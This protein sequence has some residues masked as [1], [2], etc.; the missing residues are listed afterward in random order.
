MERSVPWIK[1]FPTGFYLGMDEEESYAAGAFAIWLAW[2]YDA[3][4][5]GDI[6]DLLMREPTMWYDSLGTFG[7]VTGD[8]FPSMYAQFA[9]DFWSQAYSPV[10]RLNLDG[11]LQSSTQQPVTRILLDAD[12]ALVDQ[13]RPARSSIRQGV[14][15]EDAFLGAALDRDLVAR[16]TV[17]ADKGDVHVLK[18]PVCNTIPPVAF[19]QAAWLKADTPNRLLGKVGESL[20]YQVILVNWSASQARMVVEIVAPTI[21]SLF[22]VQGSNAGGYQLFIDGRGFGATTG[23]VAIGGFALTPTSWN[24]TTI[25]VTMPDMGSAMGPWNVVVNTAEWAATNTKP[26]TFVGRPDYRR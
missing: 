24:D 16:L 23:T 7:E 20:C 15:T 1:S 10:D 9:R 3:G 2:H 5:I 13:Q 6:Y 19:T 14:D 21:T 26:F 18:D 25:K 4:V 17:G 11:A 12:G 22:P 8:V